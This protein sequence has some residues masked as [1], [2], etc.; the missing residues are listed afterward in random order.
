MDR[1]FVKLRPITLIQSIL[2][3][4]FFN[5]DDVKTDG[6]VEKMQNQKDS[7]TV[8][9]ARLPIVLIGIALGI[10]IIPITIHL[11][12]QEI[13]AWMAPGDPLP[14]AAMMYYALIWLASWFVFTLI[15]VILIVTGV[16]LLINRKNYTKDKKMIDE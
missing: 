3:S 5:F 7:S 8:T 9:Y 14:Q 16:R 4:L 1:E 13:I 15:S 12:S 10:L 6:W 11:M 2:G